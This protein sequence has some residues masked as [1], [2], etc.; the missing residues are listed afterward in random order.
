MENWIND[1]IWKC[2]SCDVVFKSYSF[3]TEED[4]N[5]CPYCGSSQII[6]C[7]EHGKEEADE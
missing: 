1:G 4:A 6:P 3:K 5:F 2:S 7:D